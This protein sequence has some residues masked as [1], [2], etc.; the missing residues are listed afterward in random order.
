[1]IDQLSYPLIMLANILRQ[2]ISI[3]PAC[4]SMEKFIHESKNKKKVSVLSGVKNSIC[5]DYLNPADSG[6]EKDSGCPKSENRIP[7]AGFGEPLSK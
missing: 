1:M 7:S 5:K 3:R 4:A 6:R 2:L